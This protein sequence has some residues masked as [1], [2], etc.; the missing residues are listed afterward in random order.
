[1]KVVIPSEAE[2]SA[3]RPALTQN[4][5]CEA[6]SSPRDCLG[7]R[8]YESCH[9]EPSRGIC[10]APCPHAYL[11]C[12]VR[13]SPRDCLAQ[14]VYENCHPERSRGICS[15]PCPHAKSPLRSP[16]VAPRLLSSARL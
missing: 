1:M 6:R 8:V 7:Q 14:R 10:S 15:A 12:E 5:P 9:P 13:S 2:G 11:P 4:L 3:V 16:L